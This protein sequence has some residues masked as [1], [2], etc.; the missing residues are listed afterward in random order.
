MCMRTHYQ[1]GTKLTVRSLLWTCY[2]LTQNLT[3]TKNAASNI[4]V[5]SAFIVKFALKFRLISNLC[6]DFF[7]FF[8][9]LNNSASWPGQHSLTTK[10]SHDQCYFVF[11]SG[12]L[13]SSQGS[14]GP[15]SGLVNFALSAPWQLAYECP[16]SRR[17][18]TAVSWTGAF[19]N[20]SF[21]RGNVKRPEGTWRRKEWK[22]AWQD[23]LTA[24]MVMN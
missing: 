4:T 14:H 21:L 11:F 8:C 16:C 13:T 2:L 23:V 22:G 7:F 18:S 12:L 6:L 24:V 17:Y 3:L 20:W 10:V 19:K 1:S 5:S 15:L 9:C